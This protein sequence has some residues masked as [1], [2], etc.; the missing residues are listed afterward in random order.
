MNLKIA[1]SEDFC[2]HRSDIAAYIDG[3]LLPQEELELETHL[4]ICKSCSGELNEQK[5]LLQAL[6]YA[7]EGESEIELPDDFTRIIVTNAESKVSGL[8]RPQERSKA[9]FICVALFLVGLLGM[10]AETE[11]VF[12]AVKRFAEQTFAVGSFFWH[13]IYDVSVGAAIILRS[14][15]YQITNNSGVSLVLLFCF[16]FIALILLSRVMLRFNRP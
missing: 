5:K 1:E 13:L 10:G 15:S 9:L 14:L 6:N 3:E 4:A 16:G 8:R 11:T 12:S 7:L 2:L